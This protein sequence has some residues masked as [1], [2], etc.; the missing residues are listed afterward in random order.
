MM[1]SIPNAISQGVFLEN[2]MTKA[3]EIHN[4]DFNDM[5]LEQ[6]IAAGCCD[7]CVEGFS[8]HLYYGHT[9]RAAEQNAALYFYR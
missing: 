4:P 9:A 7:W 5:N 3:Y 1:Q 2:I 6:Q 8:G